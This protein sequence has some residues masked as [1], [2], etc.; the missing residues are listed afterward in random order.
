MKEYIKEMDETGLAPRHIG[1]G[2]RRCAGTTPLNGQPSCDQVV[3]CVQYLRVKNG[4]HHTVNSIK[5]LL[6][7]FPMQS[8]IDED[9][10]FMFGPTLDDDGFA[11]VYQ[12][13]DNSSFIIKVTTIGLLEKFQ[14][15][16]S[17]YHL[18]AMFVVTQLTQYEYAGVLSGLLQV[19]HK[20][21][22]V[23]PMI[24]PTLGDAEDAQYNG[25]TATDS[26]QQATFLMCFFHALYNVRKQTR[27][28]DDQT[29][30]V[31]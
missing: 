19:Y 31:V 24:D 5:A 28:L 29:G 20:L 7:E 8:G 10:A 17:K 27:Q 25:L 4:E 15:Q 3:R 16:L 26:F 18:T 14:R 6:R 13:E 30:T 11:H 9:K 21:L 22:Q 23:M 12:G 2:L 1:S